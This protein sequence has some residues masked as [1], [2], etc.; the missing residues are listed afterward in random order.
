[1]RFETFIARRYL[2]AK[3]KPVLISLLTFISLLGMTVSVFALIFVLSVMKG[4]EGDFEK[5][6][7]GFRAPVTVSGPLSTD[8]QRLKAA[9]KDPRIGDPQITSVDPYVEG[10]AVIRSE[11][12]DVLGI[13][14]RGISGT[15]D[16]GRF[17]RIEGEEAIGPGAIGPGE[18]L[19]GR[20]LAYSLR[21]DPGLAERV[22]L[23][24]PFGEVTPTGE[25]A[26][27][28]HPFSLKGRFWT[29]FYEFDSKYALVLYDEAASLLGEFARTGLEIQVQP[30]SS[31]S[32]VKREIESQ[33][34]A[35]PNLRVETL[36]VETW[37]E[38][39][40]KLFAALKLE[41][42]GMFVLLM[43]LLSIASCTIFGLISLSVLEK[44][45]DMAVMR[46]L[47]LT[48][49][50]VCRIFFQKALLIGL[51]GDLVGGIGAIGL[52]LALIRYPVKLP[53]TYYVEYLPLELDG[54][55]TLIVLLLAPFL[56]LIAAWYPARRA[57]RLGIT[58]LLRYE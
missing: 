4:F 37:E 10:E 35:I 53:T 2:S 40:P 36:K 16:E 1:M 9:L 47:G 58:E 32:R 51:L 18:I 34:S 45:R 54:L 19:L 5:R 39:Y 42:W 24:F 3:N 38:Q 20:E 12:G 21:V 41:R 13:R 50:R 15:P 7:I 29:G 48:G 28:S 33:L 49:R 25:M 46:T 11:S 22:T 27:V 52:V 31:A 6:V 43:V 14:L 26:P 56:A 17:A 23:L 30:L 44:V 8:W 55:S 57:G